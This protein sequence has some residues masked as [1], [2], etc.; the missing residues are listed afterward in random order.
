MEKQPNKF[1]AFVLPHI[2]DISGYAKDGDSD[3]EIAAKLDISYSTF[4]GYKKKYEILSAALAHAR[5]GARVHASA[6][7]RTRDDE[8]MDAL[9]MLAVGYTSKVKDYETLRYAKVDKETKVRTEWEEVKEIEKQIRYEP[10][11]DA[12]KCILE[13]NLKNEKIKLERERFKKDDF[14]L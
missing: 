8:A 13:Y 14:N 3:Q 9:Y 2:S 10:N 5:A 4:R 11:L 12:I 6:Y 1:E 7:A